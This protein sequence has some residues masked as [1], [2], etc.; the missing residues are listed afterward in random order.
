VGSDPRIDAYAWLTDDDA[1]I[2]AQAGCVTVVTGATVSAVLNAF[3]ARTDRTYAVDDTF[4]LEAHTAACVVDVPGGVV[5]VEFN[6]YQGSRAEV[7]GPASRRG[8]AASIFWNVNYVVQFT[9]ARRGRT[10]AMTDLSLGADPDELPRSLRP[11][12][13]LTESDDA[14]LVAVG[15]AM[16]DRFT[17]LSALTRE[18]VD[19]LSEGYLLDPPV[20]AMGYQSL[21]T[22]LL[23]LG[24][25]DLVE[26]I[27]AAEPGTLRAVAEE[28]AMSALLSVG[29]DSDQRAISVT[30]A[31]GGAVPAEFGRQ[32]M[33]LLIAV[34]RESAA[35]EATDPSRHGGE[36]SPEMINAGS[37]YGRSASSSTQPTPTRCK[38]PSGLS[39]QPSAHIQPRLT[40]RASDWPPP[41]SR[42]DLV[43]ITQRSHGGSAAPTR[44]E[45]RRYDKMSEQASEQRKR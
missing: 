38:R 35:I 44:R 21:E 14:D 6:G 37:A 18:L 20:E 33:A 24:H 31:F 3:G 10:L 29:L 43:W 27:A 9:C 13:S 36:A 8:K 1:T 5:A 16:V 12:L 7:L 40:L 22:T 23:R 32:A 42:N 11:M 15:M 17:G 28:A 34:H 2:L 30:S 26:M 4:L 41:N 25:L 19:G 39:T 45:T